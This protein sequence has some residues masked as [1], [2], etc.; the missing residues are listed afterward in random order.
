M[1]SGVETDLSASGLF[2]PQEQ[3][4]RN[5]KANRFIQVAVHPNAA[6]AAKADERGT[7]AKLSSAIVGMH[8]WSQF[9]LQRGDGGMDFG[10]E[11]P[12]ARIYGPDRFVFRTAVFK[13]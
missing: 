10:H 5:G 12:T 7:S 6:V 8:G 3:A 13:D 9:Q 4:G 11:V 1:I 2:C